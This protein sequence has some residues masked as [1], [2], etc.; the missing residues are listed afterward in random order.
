[1]MDEAE[2]TRLQSPAVDKIVMKDKESAIDGNHPP[3]FFRF[4]QWEP[5]IPWGNRVLEAAGG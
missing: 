4:G 5:W 3:D 2:V 1:M